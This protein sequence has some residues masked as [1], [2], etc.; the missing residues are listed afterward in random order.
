MEICTAVRHQS[1]TARHSLISISD[2]LWVRLLSLV[3]GPLRATQ[4]LR[5][6]GNAAV[7]GEIADR[8]YGANEY[9]C[10][11]SAIGSALRP[12]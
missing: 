12:Q 6:G 11:E 9:G 4:E 5:A 8:D 2:A 7:V 1:T 3:P 10:A